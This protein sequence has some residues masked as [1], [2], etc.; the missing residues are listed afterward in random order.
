MNIAITTW[1]SGP[2]AGTFFQLYGLFTYLKSRGH[3]VEV[4]NYDNSQK[5]SISRGWYYYASQPLALIKRKIERRKYN[6]DIQQVEL[7]FKKDIALR[8]KRF[9][10]MYSLMPLTEKVITDEDFDKLNNQFDIFI[11][12]SDQVWNAS[13]LN[14][15]YLLDYVH[16]DKIKASYC[17]SMGSGQVMKY[18]QK[19]FQ[20]YLKD[21]NYIST[22]ELKL[23]EI[24]SK[25]L[26]QKIEHLLD[27]SML[28]PREEYLKIA[29]LPEEFTPNSY[30]LCY[31]FPENDFQA[32]Q[33]RQFAKERNL[34]L[35]VMA[36]H[37]YSFK[38]KDAEIYAAAGPREFVGLIANAAVVFS[39]SF[40]CAIFSIMLHKDLYVFEQ[41][42]TS[43]SANTN[44]R[45][46][47]QLNCYGMNHRYIRWREKISNKNLL[48]I[49]YNK[50]ES[51]FQQRL[52]ESQA[53]LNQFC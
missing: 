47:E 29:H 17:P 38:I 6:K 9:E 8:T 15:R 45:Y 43:K 52:K 4:V 53:F 25:L 48:P 20:H 37:P 28:Y 21:F 1:H 51:I 34:K 5:D 41:H 7:A 2:N 35:V 10:E 23:K 30:L 27:P 31:F 32:E 24:L 12:G 18:Q 49:N 36:M 16:P 11:V 42:F 40:H 13:L 19:V 46:I 3:S 26:P 22:R 14:R 50:V 39:S 33:A 44:Q